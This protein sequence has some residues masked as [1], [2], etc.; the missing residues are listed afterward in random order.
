MACRQRTGGR[1][2]PWADTLAHRAEHLKEAPP[3]AR[4]RTAGPRSVLPRLA[5][6]SEATDSLPDVCMRSLAHRAAPCLMSHVARRAAL[7]QAGPGG[8]GH[9]ARTLVLVRVGVDLTPDASAEVLVRVRADRDTGRARAGAGRLVRRVPGGRRGLGP[10]AP[11]AGPAAAARRAACCAPQGRCR[12]SGLFPLFTHAIW[13]A[14]RVH[15]MHCLAPVP[16]CPGV[17]QARLNCRALLLSGMH[18]RGLPMGA[19]PGV[20]LPAADA[21]RRGGPLPSHIAR[22]RA[23][24]LAGGGVRGPGGVRDRAIAGGAAGHP[25]AGQSE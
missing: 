4:Q 23:D 12:R 24:L 22:A 15:A 6:R 3:H 16:G 9:A 8:L 17:A 14:I 5:T 18:A 19:T 13:T 11:G 1:D 20:A 21:Q 2:S 7:L 10:G 25:G